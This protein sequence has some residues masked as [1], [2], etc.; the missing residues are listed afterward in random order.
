MKF[1]EKFREMLLTEI[2]KRSLTKKGVASQAFASDQA[3]PDNK[4]QRI[5]RP[6]SKSGKYQR[7]NIA[8]AYT[9]VEIIGYTLP[10]FIW[11]VYKELESEELLSKK[12]NT[13]S[14][15]ENPVPEDRR[16]SA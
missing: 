9:L 3:K 13:K 16:N 11:K 1:E 8:D 2:E 5:L 7:I 4:M 10:D 14:T 15:L 12:K 6:S